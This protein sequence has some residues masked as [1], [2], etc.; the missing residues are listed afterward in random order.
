MRKLPNKKTRKGQSQS[1]YSGKK[2][3]TLQQEE[4]LYQVL[5][6][7]SGTSKITPKGMELIQS[8]GQRPDYIL[9]K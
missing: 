7:K 4:R 2:K 3:L 8:A 5:L 1:L 6:D 9:R